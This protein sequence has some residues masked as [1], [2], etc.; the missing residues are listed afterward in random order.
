MRGA[1]FCHVYT[2]KIKTGTVK[3]TTQQIKK[4]QPVAGCRHIVTV[5][6]I[7]LLTMLV[8][9]IVESSC[10]LLY[11]YLL[12]INDADTFFGFCHLAALEVIHSFHLSVFTF[13]L[14]NVGCTGGIANLEC[15]T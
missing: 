13:Q 1:N 5:H 4:R 14:S 11:K 9:R 10:I 15:R 7:Y 8:I 2:N 3:I 12:A 6:F